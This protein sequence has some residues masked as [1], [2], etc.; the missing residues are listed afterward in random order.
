MKKFLAVIFAL[1][2]CMSLSAQNGSV[3][4]R[5]NENPYYWKNKLPYPGYWQQ[6]IHYEIKAEIDEKT[7]IISGTERLTYWNNSP[8]ELSFV[9]F[10]LYQNAF[11]PG[12]YYHNLHLNNGIIPV[13]GS[14]E[15]LGFGIRV[16]KITVGGKDLKTELDNTIL[17]AWLD[18][19][20][21]SG[22]SVVIEIQFKTYY[23]T[24]SMRRRMKK[25]NAYGYKH[26][27]GVLWYPR[28]SVYDRK[29]G[30]TTDQHLGREFYGDYGT[31]EVEITFP[32]HYIVEA[33]GHLM[34][35]S[36]VLPED[37]RQKLD[38]RNF[39]N[40]PLGSEPS[41]IV[42]V[43]G[44]RKTWKYHAINVHDFAFTA[45]PTYRIGETEWNGIKCI[46]MV[47]EPHAAGWQN[48]AEYTAKL[49]Q[50]YSEDFGMYVYPKMIVADARDGMEYPMLTL[51]GG[52]DP[53]YRGLLAHEIAHNWFYGM[54]G[55]NET[56]RAFLDEG[57]TQFLCTW[58]LDKIDGPYG[59][60]DSIRSKYVYNHYSPATN[61]WRRAYWGYLEDA[62]RG[63]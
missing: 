22:D 46:A 37:L 19:P 7:D 30:W 53:G 3:S 27:D 43:T 17:K 54:V 13:Y 14:Y 9:F 33:T 2:M 47:Q 23:D 59:V 4:Y 35:R 41:V 11:Q 31:Y 42:P 28:I 32:S 48:A 56:Y 16:E 24:G 34:N 10:H 57:F 44:T 8:D 51:D 49:I 36:E 60:M 45:D 63:G 38:L 12:S 1:G 55:N 39:V 26:Y 58:A 15:S 61:R 40:K 21:K 20:L 25:F 62:V 50:V 6:D 5:S 18:R 29:F 52:L